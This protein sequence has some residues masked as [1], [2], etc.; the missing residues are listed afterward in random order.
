MENK[1]KKSK[2]LIITIIVII[3]LL[4]AGYLIFKNRDVFGVKAFTGIAKIFSPLIPSNNL[5]KTLVQ[6][7]ED[8]KKGD[9]VFVFDTD[10]NNN[11]IVMKARRGDSVFGFANQDMTN[12]N[13]GEVVLNSGGSNTF[14]N[15]FS[16]FIGGILGG[17]KGET[18][19]TP[20]VGGTGG[21]STSTGTGTWDTENNGST[22]TWS[23][24]SG[25]GTWNATTGI[26]GT[27]T[28]TWTGTGNG[29]GTWTSATGSGTWTNGT[30]T[31]GSGTGTWESTII[32]ISGTCPAGWTGIYP[33][34]ILI[35]DGK[36]DLRAGIVTP[37]STTIN[38]PTT[39]SSTITNDG[40]GSTGKSFL[41]FFTITIT[42][43]TTNVELSVVIPTLGAKIGNVAVVSHNF[44]S[45][46][47]YSIRACADKKSGSDAGTIIESNEDNNC[48]PWT[49]LTA[50]DS[51]PPPELCLSPKITDTKTGQ[52]INIADCKPPKVV[53]GNKCE[54]STACLSPK[55]TDTKTGQC[56]NIAD[57]KPPKVVNG[58]KC[59][60]SGTVT[61]A[62]KCLVIEQNPL[63]F[64]PEEKAR[65]AVLLRKFYLV[66]STLKTTEDIT[67]I[68]N[69]I[70][71]QK[72]FIT[73]IEGLT[74]E[75]Y[76]QAT[77]SM[78]SANSWAR[79]GNPWYEKISG[80]SFPYTNENSG[81]LR[82]GGDLDNTER[83]LNIW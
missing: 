32:D 65:L 38:T 52:C 6:A 16:S 20:P 72:N 3:F 41:S 34:C 29:T 55:I 15:S 43:K 79:H 2:A 50:T 1:P 82:G 25:S 49:T 68:Y 58:N 12:G 59:E 30:G 75:C 64:T 11:P 66:S 77:D 18:I 8:I 53:N 54:D 35:T 42:G 67:T 10:A 48:G 83:I 7:G 73:Q 40:G 22:G 70:E 63:T 62:N 45:A 23:N 81:Y 36:P 80:G 21:A 5:K 37:T 60:D 56:I 14:W 57:C 69:E 4:I 24:G 76:A 61:E 47:V 27:G 9:N 74:K 28:T 71:Q 19:P 39:L 78:M 46:G 33:N 51:L 13:I 44:S 17:N 31:G 26:G